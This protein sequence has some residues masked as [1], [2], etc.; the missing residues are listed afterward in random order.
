MERD[1]VLTYGAAEII[2]DRLSGSADRVTLPYCKNCRAIAMIDIRSEGGKEKC[3]FCQNDANIGKISVPYTFKVLM[4]EL[5][6][7]NI[8]FFMNTKNKPPPGIEEVD[9]ELIR[10]SGHQIHAMRVESTSSDTELETQRQSEALNTEP[11]EVE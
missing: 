1:A 7:I 9:E 5:L 8:V 6:K 4:D 11:I 3:Q 10:M 2:N